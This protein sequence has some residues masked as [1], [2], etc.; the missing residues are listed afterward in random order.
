MLKVAPIFFVLTALQL[1]SCKQ[2]APK[3]SYIKIDSISLSSKYNSQGSASAKIS[4]A[5][6]YINDQ[7]IGAYE[8]PCEVPVSA[9]GSTKISIVPGIKNTGQS[10]DRQKYIFYNR[11]D[12]TIIFNGGSNTLLPHVSYIDSASFLWVYDFEGNNL[13]LLRDTDSD[14]TLQW[15]KNNENAFEGNAFGEV[16]VDSAHPKAI[17]NSNLNLNIPAATKA[18]YL[19]LNYAC[20][21]NTEVGVITYASNIKSTTSIVTLK[22]TDLKW[23]KIYIDFSNA[24]G[25]YA[26]QGIFEIYFQIDHLSNKES[27]LRLDNIK[28]ISQK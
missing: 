11:F 28:I 22:S 20:S 7:L 18:T 16:T 26:A 13:P 1:L 4:D 19:E 24:L 14:T 3:P 15:L 9:S 6:I 2:E 21:A 10:G 17:I 23:N 27:K 12:S 25:N 5:W 8:L